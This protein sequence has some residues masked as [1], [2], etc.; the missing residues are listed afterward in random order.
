[1]AVVNFNLTMTLQSDFLNPISPVW[2]SEADEDAFINDL[3]KK[4]KDEV[5]LL[6]AISEG[7]GFISDPS[8]DDDDRVP[9]AM[10]D[11]VSNFKYDG[12]RLPRATS[13]TAVLAVL[14]EI[15]AEK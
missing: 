10:Y 11:Y 6:S 9:T 4:F 14:E 15:Y 5:R 2:K 8:P 13:C 1:M 7:K 3:I 12:G